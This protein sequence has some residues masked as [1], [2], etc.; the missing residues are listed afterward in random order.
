MNQKTIFGFL[1]TTCLF[2]G[3]QC[4]R[5]SFLKNICSERMHNRALEVVR[6]TL[7]MLSFFSCSR[8][9]AFI[10]PYVVFGGLV[11][12]ILNLNYHCWERDEMH[13]KLMNLN[14]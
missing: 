12:S 3:V 8:E 11:R 7:E 5:Q 10:V 14:M 13:M 6:T 9:S 2:Q 1:C 4:H